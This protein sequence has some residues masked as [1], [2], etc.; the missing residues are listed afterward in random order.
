MGTVEA[1]PPYGPGA[2]CEECGHFAARHGA[3]GCTGVTAS[4]GCAG[5]RW[6]GVLWPRP[7]LPAPDGLVAQ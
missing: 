7:W 6:L 2:L 1:E 3:G 5:M 4:C